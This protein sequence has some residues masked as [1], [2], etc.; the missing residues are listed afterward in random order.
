[1]CAGATRT[2]RRVETKRKEKGLGGR[3][4]GCLTPYMYEIV[5]AMFDK[6]FIALC[7]TTE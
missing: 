2:G 3:D 6:H 7:S 1:M 4:K 5:N